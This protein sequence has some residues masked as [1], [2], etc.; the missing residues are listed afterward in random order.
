MK[1]SIKGLLLF[2][3]GSAIGSLVTAIVLKRDYRRLEEEFTQERLESMKRDKMAQKGSKEHIEASGEGQKDETYVPEKITDLD[4][5]RYKKVTRK[6][7]TVHTGDGRELPVAEDD[8][9][10][11]KDKYERMSLERVDS[12][13]GPYVI[14]LEQFTEEC[15]H[16]DKS[17]IYYYEDDDT[18][19][20]EGEEVIT[21][22]AVTIGDD[23]LD[24]F[25]CGSED[26]EVVY[27]RNDTYGT[28]YEVIRLSKS[29]AETVLGFEKE[30][31]RRPPRRRDA[32]E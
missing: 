12:G 28:D 18:L 1:G 30:D 32:D 19:T 6:Y 15:D 16:Y 7:T 24:N 8:A 22:V 3:A 10:E 4:R 13:D 21:D 23:A 2:V 14:T 25:G 11:E 27:V 20:D 17:T 26:P 5:A 31:G 29:Y 9:I